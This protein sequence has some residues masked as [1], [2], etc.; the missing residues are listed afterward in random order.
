M[1][2]TGQ[3]TVLLVDDHSLLRGS[4]KHR[5][6]AEQDICVVASVGD[7]D[8]A[9]EEAI[10]VQPDVVLMDIDMPGLSCFDATRV[11]AGRCPRSRVVFLS[12][13]HNDRYIEQAVA[14]R[15]WGYIVK[16]ESEEVV[17]D[18]IRKV[19]GGLTYF[20]PEIQKRIVFDR[21]STSLNPQSISRV[22]KL[23]DRELEVLR[24]IAHGLTHKLVAQTMKISEHTVHRHTTNMME[25]LDIHDR[26]ELARFA[27][28][29]GLAEA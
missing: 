25:K 10:R 7:A 4:L 27:I 3:I 9:V 24:H 22:S 18:A 21:K 17:I 11:L 28:R 6:N 20:S 15:A 2:G 12:A 8:K 14:V 26:V 23:T 13:F 1:T 29:E 16:S 19:A 5:L